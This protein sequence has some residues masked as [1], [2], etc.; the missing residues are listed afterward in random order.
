MNR[1]E[2]NERIRELTE[3]VAK[4]AL[5]LEVLRALDDDWKH[6]R[7]R[8][9]WRRLVTPELRG[10]IIEATDLARNTLGS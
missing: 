8:K 6:P 7:L 2:E 9:W 4:I 10:K 1:T 5:P 3:T